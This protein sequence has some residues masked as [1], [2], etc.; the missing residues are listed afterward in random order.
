MR[1]QLAVRGKGT[2]SKAVSFKREV[3]NKI[4]L[5]PALGAKMLMMT[6]MRRPM[7]D[8]DLSISRKCELFPVLALQSV[9][10]P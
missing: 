8:G 5:T 6:E 2:V 4:I 10:S 9:F 7:T 3:I 1:S